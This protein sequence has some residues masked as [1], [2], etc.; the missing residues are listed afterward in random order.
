MTFQHILLKTKVTSCIIDNILQYIIYRI[1]L[2]TNPVVEEADLSANTGRSSP[3]N[4]SLLCKKGISLHN[5]S[6]NSQVVSSR[7]SRKVVEL[8]SVVFEINMQRCVF[9]FVD[10]KKATFYT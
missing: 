9:R 5:S 4:D 6:D 10:D 1:L 2:I 3:P 7:D 8:G